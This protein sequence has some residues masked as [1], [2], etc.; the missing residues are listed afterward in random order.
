M[1]NKA[2]IAV[3]APP[4][5]TVP[6]NGQGGT[7]TIAYYMTEGFV[8][9]GYKVTLFGAG[10]C[11]TSAKF[12]QIFKKT[13][14]QRKT[15]STLQESSRLLRL[16]NVYIAKVMQETLKR[17]KEF[18]IIF[19]HM[20]AGYLFLPFAQF[21]KPQ[22]VSILHLPIFKELADLLGS[23]EKP[24]IITISNAQRKGYNN[25]NYLGTV[26]NGIDIHEFQFNK[27]PKDYF[28]FMSALGE[29]KNPKDAILA[30]KKAR[31][32][33][34]LAGGK[35]REPY[36]SKEIAP[37]IDGKQIKYI[38]E[39]SGKKRIDLLKYAKG[40]L[41]PVK[42]PESFG[43][44][45]IESMATGTPV[46]AYNNGAVKEVIK[47][48][49]TGFIVKNVSEMAMSI[50]D[51]DKINREDCR[52]LVIRNFTAEKMVDGYEKIIQKLCEN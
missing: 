21:L 44:V 19:N 11:Q 50:K 38:G 36:F 15:N 45:M 14:K 18:D 4:F 52:N 27:I 37:L 10:N 48:K 6:P 39:V 24:N 3:I 9:K 28:L 41:F 2:H 12:C 46:I 43:L 16:E 51:I 32:K 13:I 42:L 40:F 33:L 30:C 47:H 49:K 20:R 7:E 35:K 25:I 34:V 17:Q 29:H 31:V 1:Q 5:T 23:F 8:K 26:Y 22:V